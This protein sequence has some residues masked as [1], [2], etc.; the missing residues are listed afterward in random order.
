LIATGMM[1]RDGLIVLAGYAFI[2]IT[3]IYFSVL[4]FM[5]FS[6]GQGVAALLG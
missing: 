3:V 2:A 1:Q 6:A 5:A 4:G